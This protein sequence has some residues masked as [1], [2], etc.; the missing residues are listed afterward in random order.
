M[1]NLYFISLFIF[2]FIFSNGQNRLKNT[3]PNNL[4]LN[5][6]T[7]IK[8]KSRNINQIG[9]N[10]KNAL[11]SKQKLDSVIY[12]LSDMLIEKLFFK[13]DNQGKLI[14]E[15]EYEYDIKWNPISKHEY[16]YNEQSFLTNDIIFE[17]DT[18]S[19]EWNEMEM[20]QFEYNLNMLTKRLN[21]TWSQS[22]NDW[23]IDFY[24]AHFY[25]D[26]KLN[27]SEQWS[28]YVNDNGERSDF[29]LSS[30]ITYQY[31]L[32]TNNLI[33]KKL[34]NDIIIESRHYDNGG[35]LI[36]IH[37][38]DYS[39]YN[40]N[41]YTEYISSIDYYDDNRIK[42][43]ETV[44]GYNGLN[45]DNKYGHKWTYYSNGDIESYTFFLGDGNNWNLDVKFIYEY[46]LDFI[47]DELII[48]FNYENR[49]FPDEFNERCFSHK[50]IKE[51][52]NEIYEGSYFYSSTDINTSSVDVGR[53]NYQMYPNPA[54]E[55]ITFTWQ[56]NP[57]ELSLEI[58]NIYGQK[59]FEK[60]VIKNNPVS[61]E[62]L[63][64]GVYF[65]RL[66][67]CEKIKDTGKLVIK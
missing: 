64:N 21:L 28:C 36:T 34:N 30:Y 40:Q 66:S 26:D 47:S 60:V 43:V 5:N 62:T 4:Q 25:E 22:I 11:M 16:Y 15:S 3:I 14:E 39:S 61:I 9:N 24:E 20:T 49:Y 1:K 18:V 27:R 31:D 67:D 54:S 65:Y 12:T 8:T 53:T 55:T 35:N 17:W 42:K 19:N 37:E 2:C 38:F 29:F 10:L 23:E 32:I 52:V 45:F 33:S 59:V 51:T 50:L 48:P 13:Y 63:N 58:Y 6:Y 7:L 44:R 57:V 46:D 41:N 56:D